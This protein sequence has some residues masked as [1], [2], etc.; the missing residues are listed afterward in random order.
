MNPTGV[1]IDTST[2]IGIM[3]GTFALTTAVIGFLVRML[4]KANSEKTKATFESLRQDYNLRLQALGKEVSDAVQDRKECEGRATLAASRLQGMVDRLQIEWNSFQ[5]D[6][7]KQEVTRSK[8]LETMFEILSEQQVEVKT[9]RP[10]LLEKQFELFTKSL[11]DLRGHV[12]KMV[13]EQME[14]YDGD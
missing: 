2:L 9:L 5:R 10:M 7:A 3:G 6:A 1:Q 8:R 14:S 13:R 4:L 12:R 11:E